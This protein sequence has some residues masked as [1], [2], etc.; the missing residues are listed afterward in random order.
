LPWLSFASQV[1]YET[2]VSQAKLDMMDIKHYFRD[3]EIKLLNTGEDEFITLVKEENTGFPKGIALIVPELD[4]T[5]LRQASVSNVYDSLNDYGWTSLLLTMPSYQELASKNSESTSTSNNDPSITDKTQNGTNNSN[6]SD[7]QVQVS[8]AK[9]EAPLPTESESTDPDPNLKLKAFHQTA[10]FSDS[11]VENIHSSLSA[12][13]KAGWDYAGNYPGFFL[14][15]CSGKSCGWLTQLFAQ[16]ALP[17]PDA[18]VML[19]AHLPQQDLNDEFSELLSKTEFPV[20]D[21][22]QDIDNPW[23]TASIKM[24]R[25]LSKKNF[26]TD[27]RQRKLQSNFHFSGQEQRTIKEI[28]GF[29]TAVGM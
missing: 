9:Q 6:A 19:S 1:Q 4:Q 29:L 25:Q 17:M 7:S 14:V 16:E 5:V 27:Y 24:R 12:R 10:Q 8:T 3:K 15:V 26:K 13:I 18:M 11:D 28:Y 22:Y 20:L 23:V 21:L 2:P